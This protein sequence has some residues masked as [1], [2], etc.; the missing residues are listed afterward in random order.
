LVERTRIIGKRSQFEGTWVPGDP[1]L[2]FG[3]H[4]P[5]N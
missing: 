4:E 2:I 3:L 1:S 5:G